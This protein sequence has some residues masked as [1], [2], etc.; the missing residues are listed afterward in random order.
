MNYS[1]RW[2]QKEAVFAIFDYFENHTGNPVVAM[3]TGTGK[4][5]VIGDFIRKVFQRFSDQRVM[6]LTHISKLI[7]QN[8]EKLLELWPTAPL[9]VYCA[10]LK[11][12][13]CKLPIIYG[14]IKSVKNKIEKSEVEE[15][16]I[17]EAFRHFGKIDLIVIDECH[18]LSDK[19][20]SDYQFVI[21]YLKRINPFLKVI[22]FTATP[23]RMR[24][25]SI[26][27]NGIFTHI[28]Y[29]ICDVN[30]FNR[31]IADGFLAPLIPKRTNSLIDVSNVKV[32]GDDFNQSQLE[33]VSDGDLIV[34]AIVKE[35]LEIACDRNH[36]LAFSAG[37]KN[38][39]HYAAVLNYF[40]VSSAFVHSKLSA[41]QNAYT[42]EAFKNHEFRCLVNANKLTTGFDDPA[43]D[44]ILAGRA[45][46]SIPLWVQMGGRGTRPSLATGKRDCLVGDFA[47]NCERL[48]PIND[49][50]MPRKPGQGGGDMPV[51]ICP[52]C[53]VY[54][55]A[56]ARNCCNCGYEF[57][58]ENKLTDLAAQDELI[59]G[60]APV[61]EYFN[62]R[63][64]IYNLH[65]K[66]NRNGLLL[67]APCM[68]VSYFCETKRFDEY[69]MFE[70]TGLPRYRA[71][72]WWRVRHSSEP[73]ATTFQ[74]LQLVSQ[75]RTPRTISVHVNKEYPEI[76][77]AHW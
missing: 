30:S 37:I 5:F 74:A 39:E 36:W 14:S 57:T 38:A 15:A 31:L 60:N 77:A 67:S 49:P 27:E 73:P 65:E 2:Y 18:L 43:I 55:Y 35:S 9:G 40:G 3:P 6:M 70:H 12:R 28:C 61:I 34:E 11:R 22:G 21:A 32:I 53:S 8:S 42:I 64:V 71:V 52:K 16:D 45:T 24:M 48:G 19:E 7:E 63:K 66:R 33:K 17:P 58:F 1:E 69:V 23:Y 41:K 47:R 50:R 4:S 68:K 75:L 59:A 56:A 44:Y 76:L 13:D 46:T 62:V 72:E 10:E 25:G 51:R 54:N 29:N 26:L 20:D